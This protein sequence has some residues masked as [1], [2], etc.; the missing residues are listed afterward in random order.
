MSESGL[1]TCFEPGLTVPNLAGESAN[2]KTG[3]PS[4]H[5]SILQ[6][7]ARPKSGHCEAGSALQDKII[8]TLPFALQG[9]TWRGGSHS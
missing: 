5:D 9:Q 1:A 7:K 6:L 2:N 8:P 3:F 4:I